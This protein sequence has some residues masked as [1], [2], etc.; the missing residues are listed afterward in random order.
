MKE[1]LDFYMPRI[2]KS[3]VLL[4]LKLTEGDYFVLSAHREENI[5]SKEN[6]TDFLNS[7]NKIVNKFNKKIIVSTHPRTRKKIEAAD[8]LHFDRRISFL[9]PLGFFDYVKL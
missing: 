5:D 1:I 7:L 9:K 6:F 3:D 4:R 8:K 2:K